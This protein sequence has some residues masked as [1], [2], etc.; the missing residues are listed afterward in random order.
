MDHAGE[1]LQDVRAELPVAEVLHPAGLAVVIAELAHDQ[2]QAAVAVEI[3]G[4]NVGDPG[5]VIDDR[6]RR[7][8]L[9]AVV[10]QDHDRADLVIAGEKLAHAGDQHVQIAILVDIDGAHVRGGREHGADPF[11]RVDPGR[12]LPDPADAVGQHIGHQN[13][14]QAVF[15]EIDDL[16]AADARRIGGR[17]SDRHR[18]QKIDLRAVREFWP[19]P[20]PRP[21]VR[22]PLKIC[23]NTC[24]S[25]RP[26]LCAW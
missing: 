23:S 15:V 3:G 1:A 16:E 21:A 8:V 22:A 17:K 12:K 4:A 5:N 24:A 20:L 7:E 25:E 26:E 6:M 19:G 9:L 14:R 18:R 13:V 10:L 2:V 11:F